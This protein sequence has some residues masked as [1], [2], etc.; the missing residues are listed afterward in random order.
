MALLN[1][2]RYINDGEPL[3]EVTLNRPALDVS[4]N[5]ASLFSSVDGYDNGTPEAQSDRVVLRDD[6]A[7]AK[8]GV[9]SNDQHPWRLNEFR[10]YMFEYF[11]HTDRSNIDPM[12][13][14]NYDHLPRATASTPGITQLID[15]YIGSDGDNAPTAE[16][17]GDLYRWLV[18]GG[19]PTGEVHRNRLPSASVTSS[20]I[21]KLNDSYSSNSLSNA[22]TSNALYQLYLLMQEN[23]SDVANDMPKSLDVFSFDQMRNNNP[24]V[25]DYGLNNEKDFVSSGFTSRRIWEELQE[26]IASFT[27][28]GVGFNITHRAGA[29]RLPNG[30]ILQAGF[31]GTGP[32]GKRLLEMPIA[33]PNGLWCC[34]ISE[35]GASGWVN[36]NGNPLVPTVYGI[37]FNESGLN[38]ERSKILRPLVYGARLNTGGATFGAGMGFS[39]IALG[40]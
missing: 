16:A 13:I 30:L 21:I 14:I 27:T 7:T 38:A 35:F 12:M 23:F 37:A 11:E 36:Y 26:F 20:G 17:L 19:N 5:L 22:P 39:W 6:T 33:V 2:I 1:P 32:D 18:T 24:S 29:F 9:P 25:G 34:V 8:F 3:N 31:H 4:T 15:S 10:E 28:Q 40:H